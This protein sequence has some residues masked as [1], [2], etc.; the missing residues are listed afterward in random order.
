ML[1]M[2][3]GPYILAIMVLAGLALAGCGGDADSPDPPDADAYDW[4]LTATVFV[5][6]FAAV[7]SGW[8]AVRVARISR[9]IDDL[10]ERQIE[11][12]IV[13]GFER[14]RG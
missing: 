7:S 5:V 4:R 12:E 6:V 13:Q 1:R 2:R 14:M 8:T 11:D 9:K 10:L 3:K